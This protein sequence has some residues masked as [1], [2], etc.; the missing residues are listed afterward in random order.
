M[1]SLTLGGPSYDNG[2]LCGGG[3]PLDY[4]EFQLFTRLLPVP[5]YKTECKTLGRDYYP[6]V[7]VRVYIRLFFSFFSPEAVL[8]ECHK[9]RPF[10]DTAE[11]S[12]HYLNET[13]FQ[14]VLG[15]LDR[16]KIYRIQTICILKILKRRI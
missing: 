15:I 7:L 6:R 9:I 2:T 1:Y 12:R 5:I 4:F 8:I 10:V 16:N 14:I 13:P 3:S 11:Q